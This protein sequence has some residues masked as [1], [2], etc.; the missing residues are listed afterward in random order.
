MAAMFRPAH[1]DPRAMNASTMAVRALS[2]SAAPIASGGVPVSAVILASVD[3]CNIVSA[4]RT[5]SRS[6]TVPN[7]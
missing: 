7:Q 5:A 2:S 1:G 3:H 4:A 6:A